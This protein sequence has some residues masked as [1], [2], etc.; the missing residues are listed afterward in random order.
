MNIHIFFCTFLLLNFPSRRFL[1][2]FLLSLGVNDQRAILH[3]F[4]LQSVHF[5]I[6][7]NR[8]RLRERPVRSHHSV[9][10]DIVKVLPSN[11]TFTSSGVKPR[12]L[13]T[14]AQSSF[15][16]PAASRKF[17]ICSLFTPD[18]KREFKLRKSLSK[19]SLSRRSAYIKVSA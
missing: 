6:F 13:T 12:V 18:P 15:P 9:F 7:G 19:F 8:E 11:L 10:P 16:T 1:L 5:N 14:A 17:L 2:F 4:R 3:H